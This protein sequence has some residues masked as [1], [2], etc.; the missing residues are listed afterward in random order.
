MPADEKEIWICQV[1]EI[2][3][4]FRQIDI[5]GEEL[6]NQDFGMLFEIVYDGFLT[7]QKKSLRNYQ[8]LLNLLEKTMK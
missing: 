4:E 3:R 1:V 6:F 8:Y 2:I 5:S 7:L